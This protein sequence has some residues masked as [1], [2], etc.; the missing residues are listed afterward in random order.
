M[1]TGVLVCLAV[2]VALLAIPV[3]L[4]FRVSWPQRAQRQIQLRWAFG[5]VRIDLTAPQPSPESGPAERETDGERRPKP[6]S[7]KWNF[8]ALVRHKGF[9][10]RI[11]RF[12]GDLWR[13][14]HKEDVDVHVRIGLDDPADTGQLWAFVGP[15]AGLLA[16]CPETRVRIEPD[17]VDE[18]VEMNGSGNIRI[19]PLYV[20]YLA[21]ALAI[22]PSVWAG[23]RQARAAA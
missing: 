8:V 5:L 7:G 16:N 18:T 22:S 3:V 12:M 2:V 1:L 15:V 21:A 10:R 9:R 20:L 11:L 13:A 23:M 4:Q 17:F 6:G 14:V 19:V